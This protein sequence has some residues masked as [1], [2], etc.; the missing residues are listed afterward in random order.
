MNKNSRTIITALIIAFALVSGVILVGSLSQ[1]TTE[2]RAQAATANFTCKDLHISQPLKNYISGNPGH[3]ATQTWK[4]EIQFASTGT[5]GCAVN[6]GQNPGPWRSFVYDQTGK[7]VTRAT[8]NGNLYSTAVTKAPTGSE[9]YQISCLNINTNVKCPMIKVTPAAASPSPSP[10]VSPAASA[11]VAPSTQPSSTPQAT[12]T[13]CSPKL[14][15]LN[16]DC[17]TSIEDF[18]LFLSDYRAILGL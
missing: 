13:P 15:D 7:E 5:F 3:P 9:Y 6:D 4:G 14:S 17:K 8:S 10:S 1:Q 2:D 16:K 18:A 11:S 12:I